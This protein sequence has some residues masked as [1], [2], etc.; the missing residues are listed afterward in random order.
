[1]F[2]NGPPS[3]YPALLTSTSIAPYLSM[4]S[5]KRTSRL[6]DVVSRVIHTPPSFSIEETA[7]GVA[8]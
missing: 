4:V 7:E 6:G 2:S 5:C 8:G 1:M 3:A